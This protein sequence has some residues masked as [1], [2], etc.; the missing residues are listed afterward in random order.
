M[1]A[2]FLT[3][4]WSN[5]FLA[6]Y[7]A[8]AELLEPRLPP[9]TTLDRLDGNAFVSLVAFE[10]LDTRVRGIGWPGYRSFAELNLRFYVRCGDDRGV[11]FVREFVPQRVVAWLART[12]YNEPY[13]AAPL[14]ATRETGDGVH[15][16]RYELD[17]A[18]RAHRLSVD[19][20]PS[21]LRPTEDS[22]EHFF[23]EHRWGFGVTRAGALLRYEVNHPAWDIHPVRSYAIDFD[24][25]AVYG[26]EWAFL[27]AAKPFSTV[28]AVG[29]P[30]E[31]Y[32]KR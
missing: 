15:R 2:P 4:T 21:T 3:A 25:A 31:V 16:M 19:A 5:L 24:F 23:K 29:S 8:P 1:A 12:L 18:K 11:V 32:P 14:R 20:D 17:W 7:V 10:F 9:G 13:R 26:P 30:I 27:A 28:L 6:T 22:V